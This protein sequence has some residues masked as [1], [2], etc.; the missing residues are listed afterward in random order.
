MFCGQVL[1]LAVG[2]SWEWQ[3]A[4]ELGDGILTAAVTE[5]YPLLLAAGLC[6]KHVLHLLPGMSSDSDIECDT[7]NEEPE[8]A[9][10]STDGFNHAFA[11]QSSSEGRTHGDNMQSEGRCPRASPNLA[12]VLCG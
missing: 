6:Q 12:C 5:H 2:A 3:E 9:A 7:E 4:E 11:V 1:A 10:S 8:D